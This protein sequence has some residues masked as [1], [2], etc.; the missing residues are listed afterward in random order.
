MKQR[1]SEFGRYQGY[2]EKTYD[3]SRRSSDYLTLSDGTRVAYDL[4]LPTKKGIPA[5][6][7]LPTLFLYTPY[8]RTF[9]IFDKNGKSPLTEL[10]A[11]PWYIMVAL[12]LRAR[13][14]PH[15]NLMDALFRRPWLRDL[16]K[17]GYAVVVA[18]APG[19]GASFG[20]ADLSQQGM[21]KASNEI[22]NWIAAQEWCDGNIGMFGD[23]IQ[24]Q[25]QFVAAS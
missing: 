24:A 21:A 23:S 12:K 17:S 20:K 13:F 16:M 9:T 25:V 10:E 19:T 5:D 1:I 22:L 2:T 8:L 4:F 11:L 6:K 3:G 18:E 7:P 15:G 14:A